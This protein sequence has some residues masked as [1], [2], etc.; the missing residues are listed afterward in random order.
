MYLYSLFKNLL[1]PALISAFVST[2]M[3]FTLRRYFENRI[4]FHFES[5]LAEIRNNL[6][7]EKEKAL[8]ELQESISTE[9]QKILLERK[10]K[11]ELENAK[12]IEKLKKKLSIER[13][14]N[15][16]KDFT[17]YPELVR[18]IFKTKE[19]AEEI[20]TNIDY[21]MSR[22]VDE[23]FIEKDNYIK[24]TTDYSLR[25]LH[26]SAF[27][28]LRKY[29]AILVTFSTLLEEISFYSRKE[30][31]KKKADEKKKQICE[32]FHDISTEHENIVKIAIAK[33]S[34]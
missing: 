16:Q 8:I 33:S 29:K 28:I 19:I 18:L 11:L 20:I 26:D 5:K 14:V 12:T 2:I 15:G 31:E 27:E 7:K 22:E 24:L 21:N 6:S 30:E 10:S 4:R 9:N 3:V 13:E 34:S 23:F 25:F 17:I 1:T 32:L